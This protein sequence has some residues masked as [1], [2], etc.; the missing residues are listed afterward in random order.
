MARSRNIV[1]DGMSGAFGEQ[2]V[3]KQYDY[4]T[5]VSRYPDMSG[6]KPSGLQKQKRK[7]FLQAVRF[8]QAILADA[9]KKAEWQQK[10]GEGKSV[11]HA[12]IREYLSKER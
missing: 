11:Y 6:I 9:K 8:A 7:R 4:G 10:I 5:V 1:T 3:F 2:M 12:A